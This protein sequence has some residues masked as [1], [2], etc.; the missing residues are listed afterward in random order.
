MS[1][2]RTCW[3]DNYAEKQCVY[4]FSSFSLASAIDWEE[5]KN[6]RLYTARWNTFIRKYALTHTCS[7]SL[8]DVAL[9]MRRSAHVLRKIWTEHAP[10]LYKSHIKCN[11]TKN[12]CAKKTYNASLRCSRNVRVF[13]K[14]G[15][16]IC[17]PGESIQWRSMSPPIAAL[18]NKLHKWSILSGMP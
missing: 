10:D 13:V 1:W 4:R 11:E 18:G 15:A 2:H 6:A 7:R 16:A 3:A 9:S 14:L 8:W 12:H 5:R 17:H